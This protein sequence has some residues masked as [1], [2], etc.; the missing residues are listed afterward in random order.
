MHNPC[1][2]KIKEKDLILF[3][4]MVNISA[5]GFAFVCRDANLAEAIGDKVELIIEDF[6]LL[7]DESLHA[8]IIRSSD[9]SGTFS[10]GCRLDADHAGI[11]AY[12]KKRMGI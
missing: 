5:G 7:K 12:V 8:V 3:G 1:E 6:E 10:V 4:N 9:N 2:I 11:E